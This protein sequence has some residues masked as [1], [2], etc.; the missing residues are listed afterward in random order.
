MEELF[1]QL[2]ALL[3]EHG[4][5]AKKEEGTRRYWNTLTPLQQQEVFTTISSKLREDRFVQYDPIRAIRENMSKARQLTLT[6]AEYYA[7]YHTELEQDGWRR[8]FQPEKQ[9]T[10]F[11]KCTT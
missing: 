10:I 6:Y 5:S 7:R 2:W 11:V 8:V 1:N 3:Y 4:A 9:T